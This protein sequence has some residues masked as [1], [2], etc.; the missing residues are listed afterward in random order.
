MGS[1]SSEEASLIQFKK[2]VEDHWEDPLKPAY[3]IDHLNP[4]STGTPVYICF[5][6]ERERERERDEDGGYFVEE[7]KLYIYTYIKFR[8]LMS[9]YVWRTITS[10]N[11]GTERFGPYIWSLCWLPLRLLR[12]SLLPYH[13]GTLTVCLVVEVEKWDDRK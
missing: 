5:E 2:A 1:P 12:W 13:T 9:K 10:H 7:V 3:R 6:A 11:M 8:L 4:S